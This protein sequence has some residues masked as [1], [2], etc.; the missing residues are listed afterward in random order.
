M[1]NLWLY[2][3]QPVMTKRTEGQI[4]SNEA[5]RR[6]NTLQI[7]VFQHSNNS[8]GALIA[9]LTPSPG[10]LANGN[11]EKYSTPIKQ[12]FA[13][14]ASSS[15]GLYV[16]VY[17]LANAASIDADYNDHFNRTTS[18][19]ALNSAMI[20]GNYFGTSPLTDANAI[21]SSGL[22]MSA[23]ATEVQVT[24]SDL[25]FEIP[26]V[27]LTRAVSRVRF[28]LCQQNPGM[29][30]LT[31]TGISFD[32]NMIPTQE[33]VF[34]DQAIPSSY[35]S[36]ATTFTIPSGFSLPMCNNYEAYLYD[37]NSITPQAYETLI[38]NNTGSNGELAQIG[39]YYLR[40]SGKQITGTITYTYTVENVLRNRTATFSLAA[41][42]DFARNHS[43]IIY[44]YFIGQRLVV[45]PVLIPWV[46]G[47][48]RLTHSTQ[49][50]TD[51]K[52]EKPWL[53]YDLDYHAYTWDD[54]W[55]AVAYGYESG[56]P[57]YGGRFTLETQST[58]DMDLQLT[59]DKFIFV[60]FEQRDN[61]Q[62]GYDYIYTRCGQT[63]EILASAVS[64]ITSFYVVPASDA[65]TTDR[66]AKVV[67]IE[68]HGN[69]GL[70][71]QAIPF[72]HNLPGDEDHT[73]I[74]IYDCGPSDY[75]DAINDPT[76][77]KTGN[78]TQ[79]HQLWW[80]EKTQ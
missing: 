68:R 46:A 10:N 63:L 55:L 71:P 67:L 27:T 12:T 59:S 30:D 24:G 22:P 35:I 70:P 28:V 34:D 42:G 23:L 17:V 21:A 45:Q 11:E 39:P 15:S 3:D 48:D 72:N 26:T 8:D 44:A 5:E 18:Q 9:Y 14:S 79:N 60:K 80:E 2:V 53:R 64:N 40:E 73:S 65:A 54:T 77:D 56:K 7:W 6:I 13:N 47:N 50:M 31:I 36:S 66:F 51:L 61:G 29:P 4:A 19:S 78:A 49:G 38:D 25:Q 76:Y 33:S 69:D 52:Y 57:I 1:L 41:A 16:D 37:P 20:S 32:G 74:L 75:L 58:F 43:W 62:G